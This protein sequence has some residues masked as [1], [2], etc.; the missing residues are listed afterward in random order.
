MDRIPG[1]QFRCGP[2]GLVKHRNGEY[3]KMKEPRQ[4]LTG[5]VLP[6]R[7]LRCLKTIP[8]PPI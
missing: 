5:R 8:T 4:F 3:R 1:L 2:N 6:V 7:L